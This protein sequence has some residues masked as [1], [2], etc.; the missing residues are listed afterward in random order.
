MAMAS[1]SPRIS[2]VIPTYNEATYVGR[3]LDS[4]SKQ[5]FKDFEVVVSDATSRD[6]IKKVIKEHQSNLQLRLIQTPP[7]GPA[8]GR[9]AGAKDARGEWLLFLDADVDIDDP[10]FLEKLLD[11]TIKRG[12]QTSTTLYRVYKA[13]L[14]ERFGAAFNLYYIRLMAHTRHPVAPGFCIFTRRD[15]FQKNKGFDRKLYFGED[16]DYVSRVGKSGF[17]F[18]KNTYYYQDLRRFRQ[19]N[20]TRVFFNNVIA[21]LYRHTHG[22][23]IDKP[24]FKYEFGKHQKRGD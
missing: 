14:A 5:N 15:L 2:V 4:L 13:T 23:R 16:Y 11:G 9:N 12:W 10:G 8:A 7:E 20:G 22:H 24:P 21:E 19:G 18:V 17:G 6:D 1:H 3:L